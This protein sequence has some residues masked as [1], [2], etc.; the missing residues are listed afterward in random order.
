MTLHETEKRLMK[1]LQA[2]QFPEPSQVSQAP[3]TRVEHPPCSIRAFGR[4]LEGPHL[5][6]GGR[7]QITPRI[8]ATL[9][10]DLKESE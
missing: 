8:K 6:G 7:G 9:D 5:G 2:E 10:Q 3:S 1:K 4:D